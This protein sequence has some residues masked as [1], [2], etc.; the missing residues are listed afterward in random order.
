VGT[1]LGAGCDAPEA[2]ASRVIEGCTREQVWAFVRPAESLVMIDPTVVRGFTVPGTGPGVG[3]EQC[4]IARHN[5]REVPR[6]VTVAA[7]EEPVSAEFTTADTTPQGTR[8]TLE[9]VPAGT[10][11]TFASWLQ[12]PEGAAVGVRA[13]QAAMDEQ[14]EFYVARVKALLEAG[15][16][17][18]LWP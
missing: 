17:A 5:G 7:E 14:A 16:P 8:L 1:S 12:V 9:D 4:F 11:L 18:G 3:E 2:R 15:L 10:R 13:T 6:V